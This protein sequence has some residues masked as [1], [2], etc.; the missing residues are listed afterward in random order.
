MAKWNLV[1]QVARKYLMEGSRFLLLPVWVVLFL[2][3]LVVR[4]NDIPG[5]ALWAAVWCL[6]FVGMLLLVGF[7]AGVFRA[8]RGH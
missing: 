8:L 4:H 6:P 1:L 3:E 2:Q 5:S 7:F